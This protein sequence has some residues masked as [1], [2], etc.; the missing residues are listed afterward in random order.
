[1]KATQRQR[2]LRRRGSG[3]PGAGAVLGA[4][5]HHGQRSATSALPSRVSPSTARIMEDVRKIL[6]PAAIGVAAAMTTLY[7]VGVFTILAATTSGGPSSAA[8]PRPPPPR[9]SA[10]A[11]AAGR[12]RAGT[13]LPG[14]AASG[15]RSTTSSGVGEPGVALRSTSPPRRLMS[16]CCSTTARCAREAARPAPRSARERLQATPRRHAAGAAAAPRVSPSRSRASRR[17][18]S[19]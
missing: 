17:S 5:R 4:P 3:S 8:P 9:G 15:V 16:T 19:C 13:G 14:D 11:E 18:P 12:K 1:M 2:Q 6:V 7:G 10:A